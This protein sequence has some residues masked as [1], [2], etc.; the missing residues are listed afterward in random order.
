MLKKPF[1]VRYDE[2]T[3]QA[4]IGATALLR[5]FEEAAALDAAQMA[6][7][8]EYLQTQHLAWILTHMQL[9]MLAPHAPKQTV[10]VRT[11]HACSDKILSRRDFEMTGADGSILAR[12]ASWWILMDTQ[13]RRITKNPP[14]LLALNPK[15]P[16]YITQEENFKRPLPP[17]APVFAQ[18]T[19]PVRT[20]DLDLNGHVNNVHYA[21]W[22][23]ETGPQDKQLQK[24]L[25]N[26]KNECRAGES[27]TACAYAENE[28]IYHH[29]LTRQS[30]GKEAARIVTFWQ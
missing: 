30:D 18:K 28:H 13:K 16:V 3:T 27:V 10:F 29:V 1:E 21:A 17:Q 26:F 23:L 14:Q 25:I 11:W 6:F 19:F 5:Y 22:A 4:Q 24:I 20:E 7:G 2:L 12:G 15:E 8:W 9:E